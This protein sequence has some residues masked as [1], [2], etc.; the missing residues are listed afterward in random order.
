MIRQMVI[1]TIDQTGGDLH[2][3]QTYIDIKIYRWGH[4]ESK[5]NYP[6]R[7]ITQPK[8]ACSI[9]QNSELKS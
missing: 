3:D 4:L 5:L 9:L 8:L 2:N 6:I 7:Y 1:C